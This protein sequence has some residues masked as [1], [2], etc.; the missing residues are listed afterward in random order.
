MK[1]LCQ[2]RQI[3]KIFFEVRELEWNFKFCDTI[4]NIKMYK[5]YCVIYMCYVRSKIMKCEEWKST[6]QDSGS[7][8]KEKR[9]V[10]MRSKK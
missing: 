1:Y 10:E 8:L 2:Q 6:V 9:N 4:K 3:S 5:K 7:F